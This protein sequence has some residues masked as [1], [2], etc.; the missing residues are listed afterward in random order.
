M[1]LQIDTTNKTISIDIA[2]KLDELIDI[3]DEMFPNNVWREFTL[4]TNIQINTL[5]PIIIREPYPYKY[6]WWQPYYQ[7][8]GNIEYKTTNLQNGIYNVEY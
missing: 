6:P 3:L 2:V 5:N 8:Y 4:L 1:K 7:E